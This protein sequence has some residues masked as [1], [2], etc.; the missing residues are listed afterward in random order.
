RLQG[1]LEQRANASPAEAR[2]LSALSGGSLARALVLRDTDP[3]RVRDEALALLAP[4]LQGDAQGLWRAAQAF[5]DYRR[6]GREK[7]R[8]MFEIHQLWLRDLLRVQAG[9]P[10]EMLANGDRVAELERQAPRVGPREI[11][12]RLNV[13]E[14]AIQSIEGNVT[15]DL[16]GSSAMARRPG[17]RPRE[18]PG[19]APPAAR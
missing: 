9:A 1:F 15:A 11:R 3:L 14:E 4:A 8:R 6:T 18:R 17:R 12:R 10:R 2:L 5:M 19:P 16:T 7:L 13:L